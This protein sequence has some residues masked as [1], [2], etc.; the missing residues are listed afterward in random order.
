MKR[1]TKQAKASGVSLA[2]AF[3]VGFRRQKTVDE[4]WVWV[5]PSRN[6]TVGE[7]AIRAA[8]YI[9]YRQDTTEYRTKS[10]VKNHHVRRRR[11]VERNFGAIG[12]VLCSKAKKP[13]LRNGDLSK[14]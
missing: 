8:W 13:N 7:T 6:E 3:W 9:F 2:F 11:R 1:K 5:C 4:F 14:K 10:E 12:A